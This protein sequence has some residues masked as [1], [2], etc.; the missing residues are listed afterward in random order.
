MRPPPG[1]I[2]ARAGAGVRLRTFPDYSVGRPFWGNAGGIPEPQDAEDADRTRLPK[3]SKPRCPFSALIS[4]WKPM[5]RLRLGEPSMSG[6]VRRARRVARLRQRLARSRLVPVGRQA[7]RADQ[8]PGCAAGWRRRSTSRRRC[9][10]ARPPCSGRGSASRRRSA[11]R[12]WLSVSSGLT[13]KPGRYQAWI[14]LPR[15]R[16][17][18]PRQ[19][20]PTGEA[21]N[22]G[23]VSTSGVPVG[24]LV[25][26]IVGSGA[27][28]PS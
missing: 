12:S 10:T 19:N 23:V 28:F 2:D 17:V 11:R 21:P 25:G 4:S 26:V 22:S 27:P 24:G 8:R 13:D 16:A 3:F 1:S 15:S 18:P 20:G 6:G 7:A 9:R 14:A 5:R